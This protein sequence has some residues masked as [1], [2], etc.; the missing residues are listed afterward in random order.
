MFSPRYALT[1]E[2]V[3]EVNW[4]KSF[5]VKTTNNEFVST[6]PT[7]LGMMLLRRQDLQRNMWNSGRNERILNLAFF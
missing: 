3:V 6:N 1:V 7:A 2:S 5:F 4:Q